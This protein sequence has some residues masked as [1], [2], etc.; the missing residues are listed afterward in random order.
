MFLKVEG[1]FLAIITGI[2]LD[3]L[4]ITMTCI[5]LLEFVYTVLGGMV[6]IV[7]TDFLQFL[8]LSL[9]TVL[10]TLYS[11]KVVGWGHMS[12][13][14]WKTM[15]P[16]GFNP[17]TNPSYGWAYIIFQVLLWMAVD[18]CWQTAMRTFATRDP[19]TSKKVFF[20]T[21]FIFL[22]RGMMPML[23]GIGAL[24]MGGPQYE[25]LAGDAG[26]VYSDSSHGNSRTGCFRHACSYDV[27]QQF[28]FAR[29]EFGH[30][31][32]HRLTSP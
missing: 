10:I 19:E 14:V 30:R 32:G 1:T 9:G 4:K 22:G 8:A 2:P 7:I 24:A 3:H 23:W 16:Q 20:W 25:S 26:D 18:T 13:T 6:S 12:T 28:L 31:P 15:G 21:G 17:F 11:I 29:L 5:L 27:R